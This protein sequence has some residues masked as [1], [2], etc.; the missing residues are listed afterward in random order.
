[1]TSVLLAAAGCGWPAD[2]GTTLVEVEGGVLRVGVTE[3]P[4]WSVLPDDGEPRGAEV[5]LVQRLADRLDARVEWYPGSE[6]TLMAALKDRVLALVIGGLTEQA[7]WTE[8]ASF[9]RPYVTMRT[10]VAAAPG[11]PVPADLDGIPVTVEAGTAQVAAVAAA[12]AVVT[13]VETVTGQEGTPAVVDE[14]QL[15]RLD[16][17]P[18]DHELDQQKHVWAVPPGEN[19]WQVAVERFLLDLSHDEV[20]RLLVEADRQETAG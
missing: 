7:P 6:S 16:L 9:T 10:V 20:T 2:T 1:M 4:P 11:V 12:G 13:P 17:L 14:W 8:A 15:T 18:S 5:V 19:G 3:N